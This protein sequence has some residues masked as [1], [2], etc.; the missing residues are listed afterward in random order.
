MQLL[1]I[2]KRGNHHYLTFAHSE[3]DAEKILAKRQSMSI[4]RFKKEYRLKEVMNKF[5]KPI[6]L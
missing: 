1:Y 4:E 2:Y 6:K 5:S 3:E